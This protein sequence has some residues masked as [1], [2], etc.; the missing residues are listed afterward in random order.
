MNRSLR[1]L[2]LWYNNLRQGKEKEIIFMSKN[3]FRFKEELW[4]PK[5]F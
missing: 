1:S 2:L 5:A 4:I 3:I